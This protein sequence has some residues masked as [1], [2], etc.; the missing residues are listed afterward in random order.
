MSICNASKQLPKDNSS[1]S[2]KAISKEVPCESY[3]FSS[4]KAV[5]SGLLDILS[6]KNDESLFL[7]LLDI[8]KKENH[9]AS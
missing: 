5:R 7:A 4:I 1:F 6:L 2:I 3:S 8:N 9:I